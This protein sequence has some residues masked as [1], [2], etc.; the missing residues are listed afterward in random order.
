MFYKRREKKH[1]GLFFLRNI[2]Y[3]VIHLMVS[4]SD[5]GFLSAQMCKQIILEVWLIT[6]KKKRKSQGL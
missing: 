5:L 6:L 3:Y 4:L 1:V 2:T